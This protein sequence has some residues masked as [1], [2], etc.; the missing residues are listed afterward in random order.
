MSTPTLLTL[1]HRAIRDEKLFARGD[2]I[3]VGCSGGPDS[4]ALLHALALLRK[5]VGHQ[6]VAVA[7]D[8]GLRAEAPSELAKAREVADAMGVPFVAIALSVGAGAN[9]Q[10]RARRARHR[11]LQRAAAQHGAVAVATGHT[12][13]DRAETLLM[14]LLRGS[15]PRGLAVLPAMAPATTKGGVPLVRP[16]WRARR[17]DVL[18]HLARHRIGFATDPSNLDARF[19]RVRVRHDL[20]PLLAELS[21]GVVEHLCAL[22]DML[23][24]GEPDPWASLGRAQRLAIQRALDL[25]RAEIRLRLSGGREMW[26]RIGRGR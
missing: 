23:G 2:R 7:I 19:L 25:G 13:D 20:L 21:P 8:H 17:A 1:A 16:L 24:R 10:D 26:L 5:R 14:R 3:V 12:A 6:L 22:A 4:T 15:G 11:A 9:L 18:A